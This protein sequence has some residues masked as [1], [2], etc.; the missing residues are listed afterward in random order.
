[1]R[2]SVRQLRNI[3]KEAVKEIKNTLFG[4]HDLVYENTVLSLNKTLP[5]SKIKKKSTLTYINTSEFDE[6]GDEIPPLTD[7][8][9][10]VV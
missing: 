6:F 5:D 2:I 1:M 7:S 9:G 4:A 10:E 3:V 8:E